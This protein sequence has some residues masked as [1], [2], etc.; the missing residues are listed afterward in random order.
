MLQGQMGEILRLGGPL[1]NWNA[2]ALGGSARVFHGGL[3][4][5]SSQTL[6]PAAI[7]I[8]RPN[9]A[10]NVLPM[11]EQEARV[12]SKMQDVRGVIRLFAMGFLDSK[13]PLTLPD[14]TASDPASKIKGDVQL[15]AL[16]EI[17]YFLAELQDRT[18]RDADKLQEYGWMPPWLP[19]LALQ[20]VPR[21]ENLL[22]RCNPH[23]QRGELF[24]IAAGLEVVKQICD[25]L[26]TAHERQ[27]VYRDHKILHYYYDDT[28]VTLIDWNGALE[29]SD[30]PG[31][32]LQRF[33]QD[34]LV[35]FAARSLHYIM[36]GR[37]APGRIYFSH[38]I[39]EIDAAPIRYE[40]RWDHDD[41]RLPAILREI[42]A[43]A[44]NGE[45]SSAAEL[46][47]A[48]SVVRL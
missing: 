10:S 6:R 34:D 20:T 14:D 16:N 32:D 46:S 30:L 40:P 4:N 45:F 27:I 11:F 2:F 35:Q 21:Q 28:K 22:T 5:Q 12:L 3:L 43:A 33:I 1:D 41:M 24:P 23:F 47:R 18:T 9:R 39:N 26:Q 17:E 31:E 8:M 44:L 7:K 36:T 48:I 19:F 42:I 37:D 25:I 15:F 38:R 29:L 13:E